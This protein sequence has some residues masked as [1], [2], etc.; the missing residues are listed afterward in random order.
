M[1]E[2][3]ARAAVFSEAEADIALSGKSVTPVASTPSPAERI[4][5]AEAF[6][7]LAD[8]NRRMHT[9]LGTAAH[10]LKTPLAIVAGYVDLLLTEK[11]GR[12]EVR[13]RTILEESSSHCA[14]LQKF[15]DDFL[16]YS[17]LETGN[18]ALNLEIRD[19]STCLDELRGYWLS[20][21]KKKGIA[22]D[23]C[24]WREGLPLVAFDYDKVQ[25]V[26]SNLLENSLKFTSKGGHVEIRVRPFCWE[27]RGR[28][29]PYIR[30]ER[31]KCLTG[32]PNSVRVDVSDTGPGIAPE[33]WQEI[34][35]DFVKL[36]S[37]QASR[38]GMG[39][40]LA[41]AR[42][43]VTAHRGKIWV[44]GEPGRGSVFAFVLPLRP[45]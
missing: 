37:P 35:E 34:F 9:A 43:L 38:E 12:L 10:Q 42:R 41:I 31:R 2:F 18:L 15:I 8:E 14:R 19:L 13:Q 32:V 24:P 11:P 45:Y 26:V 1:A 25:H 20:S 44:E 5:T 4:R 28:P 29:R 40:G 22:L 7:R 3:K 17:A 23:F 36:D 39:L 33:Y 30:T 27:R 21:F 16:S 6:E